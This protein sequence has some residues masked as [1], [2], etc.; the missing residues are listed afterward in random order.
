MKILLGQAV[1][2]RRKT[3]SGFPPA[4][5]LRS[6]KFLGQRITLVY[7]T[8]GE[9]DGGSLLVH[10]LVLYQKTTTKFGDSKNLVN[11]DVVLKRVGLITSND[12]FTSPF[13]VSD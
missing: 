5:S 10:L 3:D 12:I 11:N 7:L 1:R 2:S 9:E 6:E 13:D 8:S 4:T